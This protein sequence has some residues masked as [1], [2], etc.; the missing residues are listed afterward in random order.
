M[1]GNGTMNLKNA[2]VGSSLFKFTRW[3]MD[4]DTSIFKIQNKLAGEDDKEERFSL[5]TDNIKSHI[6]FK[7]HIGNFKS[8]NG[9][10]VVDLPVNQYSTTTDKFDWMMQ[11]EKVLFATYD[12]DLYKSNNENLV[13]NVFSTNHKQDS[14]QFRTAKAELDLTQNVFFC[15]D[16]KYI[17]VADA[18]IYP[19]S[20]RVVIHK[21]A[22]MDPLNNSRIIAN[23]ITKYHTFYNANTVISSR[24]NFS[25]RGIYPYYDAD[26]V[27]T[28]ITVDNIYV[29]S[30]LHT[31][32][33]GKINEKDTF[34]F[35]KEFEYYGAFKISSPTRWL[36]FKGS[37]RIKHDCSNFSRSWMAFETECFA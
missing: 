1:T 36:T 35:S 25:S 30:N 22:K 13:S 31:L 28:M 8:N 20:G 2:L 15:N 3:D 18:R 9:E 4:A 16:T 6:S 7:E 23:R 32:G 17:D 34:K 27:K 10:S 19:D 21:K 11:K 29:D 37:T 12:K 5:S 33:Y 26:S 24:K 14:L